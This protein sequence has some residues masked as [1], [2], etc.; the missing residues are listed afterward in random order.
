MRKSTHA[1]TAYTKP[2]GKERPGRKSD[3]LLA[4]LQKDLRVARAQ[5]KRERQA[6]LEAEK[7][8]IK[9]QEKLAA[10]HLETG[11][12]P[13]PHSRRFSFVV[14]LTLDEQGQFERTEIEHVSSGRKQNFLN[15]DGDR[16]VAFMKT[17]VNPET[18]PEDALPK[19]PH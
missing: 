13:Q 2:R 8:L 14:R 15:L 19:T 10:A 1:K 18:I 4:R 9:A 5:A 3:E 11:H 12:N 16:L 7:A 6:R 17:C